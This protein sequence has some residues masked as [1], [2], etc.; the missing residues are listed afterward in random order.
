LRFQFV[1]RQKN[2]KIAIILAAVI[3]LFY[4]VRTCLETANLMYGEISIGSTG[5]HIPLLIG[6][7][8]SIF[9]GTAISLIGSLLKPQK[10]NYNI[11]K[12]KILVVDEKIRSMMVAILS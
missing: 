11:M 9:L 1:E 8:T 6:N 12:Q 5:H 7:I 4:S 3:G 2:F 10:F